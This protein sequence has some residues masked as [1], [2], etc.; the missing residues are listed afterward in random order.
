MRSGKKI[1]Y[2]KEQILQAI[3]KSDGIILNVANELNCSWDTA[4]KYINKWQETK[5]ALNDA[6][7]AAIDRCESKLFEKIEAGDGQM[8]RFF[9]ATKGK[10]RGYT[11]RQE[12]TG[13]DGEPIRHLVVIRAE[14]S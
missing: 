8:I 5:R 9:L 14:G 12:L 7:E 6:T 10:H 2:T 1:N 3:E 4:R 11:E 13:A